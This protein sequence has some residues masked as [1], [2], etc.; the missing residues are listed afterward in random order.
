M[1]DE[2]GV[3]D[4]LVKRLRKAGATAL[5]LDPGT[6]TDD[7]LSHLAEW[8]AEGP[9]AGVYWLAALDD[10]GDL[11]ALRPRHLAEALRRRVKALYATMRH[12][13][14]DDAFLVSATRLGGY[15]GYAAGGATSA[16]GGAVTGFTKSYKKER[17]DAV[18][19]AVDLPVDRQDRRRRRPA[20]RGDP[21][22]PRLRRGRPRRRPTLR[23]R[24]A[25]AAVPGPRGRRRPP[26]PTA[27]CR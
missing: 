18:V 20:H 14:D 11:A 21:A 10:E 13:W 9:I 8:T 27:G 26:T 19:K 23:H 1:R 5:V 4:A 3:G 25:G 16:L 24:P 2:G 7:V 12:L 17:P 6:P 15:H 22:R